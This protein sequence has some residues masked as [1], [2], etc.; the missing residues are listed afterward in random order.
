MRNMST[1]ARGLDALAAAHLVLDALIF[2]G[3]TFRR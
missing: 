1:T 2:G 3:L